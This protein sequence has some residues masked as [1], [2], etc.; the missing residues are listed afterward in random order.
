ML[1]TTNS[2]T[3]KGL[4]LNATAQGFLKETAKWT[5][6]FSILGFIGVGLFVIIAIFASLIFSFLN[7]TT[8]ELAQV[9]SNS[10]GFIYL[11]MAALY[12]F[13]V[14]YLYNFSKNTKIALQQSDN[15]LLSKAFENLKSHYKFIGILTIVTLLGY[16]LGLLIFFAIGFAAFF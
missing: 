8:S 9:S 10:F 14:Y 1:S 6:F 7:Q 12:F 13:P 5:H 11:A 16:L 4:I 2:N 3:H 15:I